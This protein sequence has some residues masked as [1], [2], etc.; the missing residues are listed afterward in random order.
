MAHGFGVFLDKGMVRIFTQFSGFSGQVS[1]PVL[2]RKFLGF[3]T[4]LG[5]F[6][7]GS[8]THG[9]DKFGSGIFLSFYQ[10]FGPKIPGPI[11]R[12]AGRFCPRIPEG[13]RSWN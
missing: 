10:R 8:L 11:Y 2:V 1:W 7:V 3:W 13:I 6:F 5:S 4:V 12:G 9:L